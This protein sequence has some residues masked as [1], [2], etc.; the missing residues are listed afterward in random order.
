MIFVRLKPRDQRAASA[1]Q[2]IARLQARAAAVPGMR[3]FMQVPPPIRIGGRLTK[4]EYQLTLQ[5]SDTAELYRVTPLLIE[6]LERSAA[7]RDVT[8]D[9]QIKNP[10]I[11]VEIDRDRAASLGL[12]A[13]RIEEALYSA[14][15]TRQIS[16]IFAPDDDYPVIL[17]LDPRTQREPAALDDLYVR[18]TSGELVPLRTVA[19]IR[20]SVGPLT[21]THSGQLPAVTV[22]FDLAAG[23]SLGEAVTA[24]EAATERVLPAGVSARFQGRPEAV[25]GLAHW[26][27][28]AAPGVDLRHLR[29]AGHPL[30]E[31]DHPLT[32]LSALPFAGFGAVVTCSSSAWI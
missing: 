26:P 28:G 7:L 3:V 14:Y 8:S 32:I 2:V 5:G 18:A 6:E 4:S 19:R 29:G 30:R 11:A 27:R 15:G 20:P 17:E 13:E 22:S 24:V 31:H 10:E 21:V 23:H 1:E 9:L 25:P 12:T 16:T